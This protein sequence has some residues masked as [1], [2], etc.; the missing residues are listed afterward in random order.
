MLILLFL[1]LCFN[2]VGTEGF[3]NAHLLVGIALIF[4]PSES[5]QSILTLSIFLL[6]PSRKSRGAA[7]FD[8]HFTGLGDPTI[9]TNYFNNHLC[10][11]LWAFF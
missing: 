7:Q 11:L 6:S 3:A 8:L 5:R 2:G 4:R 1:Q 9:I 10:L